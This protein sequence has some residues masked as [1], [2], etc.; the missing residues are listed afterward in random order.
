PHPSR[1]Y[2]RQ[3]HASICGEI[4]D[5]MRICGENLWAKRSIKYTRLS[6]FFQ[7]FSIWEGTHCLSWD[8]T[9]EWVQLLGLTLVPVLYRGPFAPT[10]LTLTGMNTKATWSV[11]RL[12]SPYGNSL[13]VSESSCGRHTSLLMDTGCGPNWNRTQA[14]ETTRISL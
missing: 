13:H 10:P 8:G 12:I 6:A 1:S 5:S 11:R 3:L 14:H 4:P 2:V 9:V 7:V